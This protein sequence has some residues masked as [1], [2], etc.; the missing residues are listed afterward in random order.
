[1]TTA[2]H[3]H[4]HSASTQLQVQMKLKSCVDKI[5]VE[6]DRYCY[7]LRMVSSINPL[8]FMYL[9]IILD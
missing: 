1:M 2:V 5:L 3:A 6:V 4:L 7:L 9:V 8:Y